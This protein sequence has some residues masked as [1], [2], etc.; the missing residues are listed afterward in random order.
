MPASE[1]K[2]RAFTRQGVSEADDWNAEQ[3]GVDRLGE[4]LGAG[5]GHH[6][7]SGAG[8]V[9]V[10]GHHGEEVVSV[11]RG[12]LGRGGHEESS[13][14]QGSDSSRQCGGGERGGGDVQA[15]DRVVGHGGSSVSV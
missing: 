2:R 1:A 5:Q 8:G 7:V 13:G 15:A 9:H 10:F 6:G 3:R 14:E 4:V 12:G 11:D